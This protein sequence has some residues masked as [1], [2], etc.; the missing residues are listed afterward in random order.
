MALISGPAGWVA[1]ALSSLVATMAAAEI[2]A[3]NPV[4]IRGLIKFAVARLPENQ[5]ERFEEEWHAHISE[6]PGQIAKLIAAVGLL[7]VAHNLA[8]D[9][10]RDQFIGLFSHTLG[11]LDQALSLSTELLDRIRSNPK[12]KS[13]L[14]VMPHVDACGTSIRKERS[15][16][17]VLARN[18]V[19]GSAGPSAFVLTLLHFVM[20]NT[21]TKVLSIRI[22]RSVKRL[23]KEHKE[24]GTHIDAISRVIRRRLE[25][26]TEPGSRPTAD[27]MQ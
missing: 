15:A 23:K 27:Q 24:V 4:V 7:V 13:L 16:C 22:G 2:K 18:V 19:F 12:T 8:L 5:R 26:E 21:V 25:R 9:Y 20:P 10:T 6:V 11:E 17:D 14:E 1:G 3:W